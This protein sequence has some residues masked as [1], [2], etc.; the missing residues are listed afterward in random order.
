MGNR[1]FQR[2]SVITKS[3]VSTATIEYKILFLLF[4]DWAIMLFL[5]ACTDK[6]DFLTIILKKVKESNWKSLQEK[7]TEKKMN[8]RKSSGA[9]IFRLE[10]K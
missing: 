9:Y 4:S 3:A 7:R 5:A 6:L 1:G 8:I 10:I 2:Q